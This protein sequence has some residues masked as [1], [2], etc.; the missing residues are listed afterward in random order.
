VVKAHNGERI[1][2]GSKSLDTAAFIRSQ[3][4]IRFH[5]GKNEKERRDVQ[6]SSPHASR[7]CET[8]VKMAG[9]RKLFDR[10]GNGGNGS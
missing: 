10:T 4:E 7:K 2:R 5:E 8:L 1:L 9:T 3:G 6:H